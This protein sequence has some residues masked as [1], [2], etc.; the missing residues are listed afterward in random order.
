M[1]DPRV[2]QIT[3][4]LLSNQSGNGFDDIRVYMGP[5]RQFGQ[6]FGDFIRN[7]LCTAAPV[8]LRVA[9]TLFKSS[10]ESIKDGNSIG[11][12]FKSALKPI[13]RTSLNHGG[14]ALGK[15]IQEQNKFTAAPP[16]EQPPLNQNERDAGTVTSLKSQTGSGRYKASRKQKVSNRFIRI[17]RPNVH[18]NFIT[19]IMA[20]APQDMFMTKVML[21]EP[22]MQQLY[23]QKKFD[24][25]FHPIATITPGSLIEFFVKIAAKLYLDLNNSRFMVGFRIVKKDGTNMPAADACKSGVVNLRLHLLF[26]VVTVLFNNKMVS[27]Q[28]IMYAYRSY[29]ETLLNCNGDI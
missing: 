2:S 23:L 27:D 17:K 26:Q 4:I 20:A 28:G 6:K 25:K 15:V 19:I 11:D 16:L 9:K 24:R 21:F 5:S 22:V 10:S 8:I 14:K 1:S 12:S 18:Y 7:A 3:H 29:L 13:L